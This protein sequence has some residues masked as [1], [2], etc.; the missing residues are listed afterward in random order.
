MSLNKLS[1]SDLDVHGKKVL[2]RC[3]FNVPLQNGQITDDRRIVEALPTI[4]Y[5]LDKRAAVI[6]ASHLGRPKGFTP[7]FSLAPVAER[8]TELLGMPVPLLTDCV[9]PDV[10]AACADLQDGQV[11]L[12]E[13]LRFHPEEEANDPAFAA[14][15][16]HL[17]DVYV[18]DAFGTAHRAH[19]STEGVA[20]CLRGAAGFLMQKEIAFLGHALESPA[21]P[22]VAILGGAKVKDKLA[23]I[24][25]LLPKVDHL[26]IGGGRA[27]T[28]L[29]A[30][31]YEIGHSLLDEGSLDYA[32]A[33]MA[34]HPGKIVLPVDI[35][36]TPEL[37][38]GAPHT[39]VAADAIPADELGA[40]IG[41]ASTKRFAAIVRVAGT[42]VWNGPMGVFEIE[43]FAAGTRGVALALTECPGTTIVGGG[44]S[45]AA[46]EQFG[47]ASKVYSVS[48]GGGAGLGVLEGKVL[49]GIAALQD[50][51]A[52]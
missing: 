20:H 1:V 10:E 50:I 24:D 42:V 32:R 8:L 16:A 22:F 9:G 41:P 2:V 28:F 47:L 13:N 23:V 11:L 33:T 3:D 4:R 37:V 25:S 36:V 17:A 6:L 18:N 34:M 39:L 52:P 45:A 21:R 43:A 51:P 29:K 7:E 15:L 46:I 19:A 38:E 44:D 48:A 14:R 40:D 49:P 35:V 31:G 26:W 5:L 30:L 12:L 27:C